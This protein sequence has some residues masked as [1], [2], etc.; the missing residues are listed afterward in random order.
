MPLK[1]VRRPRSPFWY[2]RGTVRGLSVT[3]STGTG[4]RAQAEEVRAL[5]EAELVRRSIHGDKGT[6]TFGEAALSYMEAGGERHH[7]AP[8]ILRWGETPLAKI[9]QAEIDKAARALKP[10]A[11]PSTLNRCVYTPTAAVLHHAARLQWCDKPVIARPAQPKGRVRWITHDEADRLIASAGHLKPLVIFLLATGAR[12]G[13]ALALDWREV[14]LGR[15]HVTFLDT[16]NGTDRG[17]PLHSR[18]VE[19]LKA[20]P[21]R[22]GAV[23]R[24]HYGGR[25]KSGRMR[26]V[27]PP[28]ADRE[29]VG[30]GQVKKGWAVMLKAAKITDFTPHDCRHTWATWHYMANRDLGA[31]MSLGGWKSVTMVMRYAHTN[32]AQHASGMEAAWRLSGDRPAQDKVKPM[33]SK[34]KSGT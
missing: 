30:G 4:D 3:E 25:L 20:L 32:T 15:A 16:K 24:V 18:A 1:L 8:L 17:V 9:G 28:Y 23:F 13:E 7:L 33:R 14:D 10:D 31:L 19:A 26:P 6:R 2:M 22:E 12:I 21:H 27:G 29:G 34:R 11:G 5:R